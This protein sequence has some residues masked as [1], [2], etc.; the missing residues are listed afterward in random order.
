MLNN[1][2]K[3][4]TLQQWDGNSNQNIAFTEEALNNENKKL[5][6]TNHKN[7]KAIVIGDYMV[8]NINE[9]E[10]TKSKKVLVRSFPGAMSE[11]ILEEMDEIIKEKPDSIISHTGVKDLTNN[12][13]LL[14]SAK[15]IFKKVRDILQAT[16]IAFSSI[17]LRKNR[18]NIN[19]SRA[20]FNAKLRNFCK[21]NN[22]GF[23][24]KWKY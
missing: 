16:K 1:T 13:N 12:I 15:K 2:Y 14:N 22:I 8:N 7:K 20:D 11:K 4:G 24:D 9:R 18:Q 3:K 23:I 5:D 17:T 21:Q 19:E 6:K 10:L